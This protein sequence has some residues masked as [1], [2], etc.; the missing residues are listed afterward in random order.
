MSLDVSRPSSPT[1]HEEIRADQVEKFRSDAEEMHEL[2]IQR[3]QAFVHEDW[4]KVL[5]AEPT[6]LVKQLRFLAS[7]LDDMDQLPTKFSFYINL[8]H[9]TTPGTALQLPPFQAYHDASNLVELVIDLSPDEKVMLEMLLVRDKAAKLYI[10]REYYEASALL[11]TYL[12]RHTALPPCLSK[13][14]NIISLQLMGGDYHPG[15][16][17]V[18]RRVKDKK[19][20]KTPIEKKIDQVKK[21]KAAVKKADKPTVAKKVPV[22]KFKVPKAPKKA[23]DKTLP[24]K[25]A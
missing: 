18:N 6:C 10:D 23:G 16:F 17:E 20:K 12:S 2:L 24:K 22:V 15:W 1:L 3:R 21:S 11:C 14:V 5:Y 9:P 4:S 13:Y 25:E 8:E 7:T 19:K